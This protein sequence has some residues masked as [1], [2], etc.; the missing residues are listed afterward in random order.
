MPCCPPWCSPPRHCHCKESQAVRSGRSGPPSTQVSQLTGRLT[1]AGGTRVRLRRSSLALLGLRSEHRASLGGNQ[2]HLLGGEGPG[3]GGLVTVA[4]LSP[5]RH[6]TSGL[7]WGRERPNG[8]WEDSALLTEPP[9][10]GL[11][12]PGL[13]VRRVKAG[14]SALGGGQGG[15]HSSV[16]CLSSIRPWG[17]LGWR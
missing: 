7:V 8:S 4:F 11:G 10:C 2:R 17:W 9:V 14:C 12:N 15:L 1:A 5:S 13:W 16:A 3:G 6:S